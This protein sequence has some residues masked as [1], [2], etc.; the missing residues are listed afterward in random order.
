MRHK[1]NWYQFI[2]QP[3]KLSNNRDISWSQL[4]TCVIKVNIRKELQTHFSDWKKA[5]Q[6]HSTSIETSLYKK[7]LHMRVVQ[8]HFKKNGSMA[9]VRRNNKTWWSTEL[10]SRLRSRSRCKTPLT[11]ILTDFDDNENASHCHAPSH[12]FREQSALINSNFSS[13]Y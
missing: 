11:F 4:V 8:N 13:I 9:A 5:F 12:K 6:T 3:Q 1:N 2:L 7:T 10:P